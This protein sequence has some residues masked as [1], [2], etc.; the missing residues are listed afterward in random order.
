MNIQLVLTFFCSV[1]FLGS[2]STDELTYKIWH[3]MEFVV[4]FVHE[5]KTDNK[6]IRN[7]KSFFRIASWNLD[8]DEP[9]KCIVL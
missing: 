6:S 3:G 4:R 7:H 5:L 2:G 1:R 9:C 8:H